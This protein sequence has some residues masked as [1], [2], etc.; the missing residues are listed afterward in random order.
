MAVQELVCRVRGVSERQRREA[1]RLRIPYK[2]VGDNGEVG[3]ERAVGPR[4][5]TI[6]VRGVADVGDW[7]GNPRRLATARLRH[8]GS[9][10]EEEDRARE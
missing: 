3:L 8:Q 9:A 4:R 10:D 5:V 7:S 6:V 2:L 1:R